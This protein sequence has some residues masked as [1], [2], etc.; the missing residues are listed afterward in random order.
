MKIYNQLWQD[1]DRAHWPKQGEIFVCLDPQ[2]RLGEATWQVA[3]FWQQ[4]EYGT[5]GLDHCDIIG[6]G[7]FWKREDAIRFAEAI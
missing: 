2:Q 7:L 5:M 4:D 6:R 1:I 3:E